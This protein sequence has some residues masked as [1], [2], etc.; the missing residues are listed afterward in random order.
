MK[1]KNMRNK[2]RDDKKIKEYVL[3]KL[4]ATESEFTSLSKQIDTMLKYIYA[5]KSVFKWMELEK[6]S[7]REVAEFIIRCIRIKEYV[8][9]KLLATECEF[10][11]L[12]EL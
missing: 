10:T 5:K 12:S 6:Q 3:D 2:E 7:E 1:E 11:S 4:L 8:L 9:D